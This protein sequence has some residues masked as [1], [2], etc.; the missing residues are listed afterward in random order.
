MLLHHARS[1][2]RQ[3][4]AGRPVPLAEQNRGLWQAGPIAEGTALLEQAM[5]RRSPGPYQL[6]AA[7]A[8]VHAA[9]PSFER[10]DW[11]Q[12]ATLYAELARR[13]PSPVIDVNRAVATGMAYGPRAGLAVLAP[14]L[15]SGALAGYGPLHAA[16]ADL[17]DRCG[18]TH[19]AT[20]AWDRAIELTRND[21]VRD[22]LRRRVAARSLPDIG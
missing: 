20:A 17:L 2:G 13:A 5:T 3:D 9:A 11:A 4:S 14:T 1:P 8:A 7:I 16:H 15:A 6:Q 12:I 19:A 10:T 22:E 18:E 21:V